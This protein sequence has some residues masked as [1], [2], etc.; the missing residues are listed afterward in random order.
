MSGRLWRGGRGWA[1]AIHALSWLP[2]PQQGESRVPEV[3]EF[4][5][6]SP[7]SA[8]VT[9]GKTRQLLRDRISAGV[10]HLDV[11]TFHMYASIT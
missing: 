7:G 3:D 4:D 2:A 9:P 8:P 6:N 5:H 10:D 1:C 11:F